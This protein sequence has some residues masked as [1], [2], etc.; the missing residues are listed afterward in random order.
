MIF[1]LNAFGLIWQVW[2][3]PSLAA[4]AA[5]EALQTANPADAGD[6]ADKVELEEERQ[7]ERRSKKEGRSERA[8]STR[9]EFSKEA[10]YVTT[11]T[12]R[13]QRVSPQVWQ[14]ISL[15]GRSRVRFKCVLPASSSSSFVL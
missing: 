14:C 5:S 10:T 11:T 2:G 7:F 1:Y 3:V 13:F 6:A 12:H 15:L 4:A 9:N 8:R